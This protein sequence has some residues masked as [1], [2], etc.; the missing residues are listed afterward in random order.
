MTRR[1]SDLAF[2]ADPSAELIRNFD[3]ALEDQQR[4]G[5]VQA[6]TWARIDERTRAIFQ[7]YAPESSNV[8]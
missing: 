7:P 4:F 1:Q 5:K 2:E 6:D 3:A 8:E